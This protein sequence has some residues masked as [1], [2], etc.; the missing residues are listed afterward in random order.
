MIITTGKHDEL[1]H[2]RL[3]H[4]KAR[5]GLGKRAHEDPECGADDAKPLGWESPSDS[6]E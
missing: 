5:K 4:T 3:Y 6:D 2:H 1:R